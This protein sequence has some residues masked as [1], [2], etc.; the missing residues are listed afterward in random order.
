MAIRHLSELVRRQTEK[1]GDRKPA[2]RYRDDA[3][4]IWVPVS[5]KQFEQHVDEAANA[6]AV[7]GIEEEENVGI[8]SQNMVESFYVDFANF[9]NRAVTVP[10]YATSSAAQAQYI[11]NDTAMRLLFVG[12]QYQYDTIF[13][14]LAHCHTLQHIV[15][16]DP[17]VKRDPRDTISIYFDEFISKG[18]GL[19]KNDVVEARRA[20]GTPED[21]MNILY[22]SGT[23]GEPKGVMLTHANIIE[24]MR[25]HHMRLTNMNDSDVSLNFL[26]LTHVFERGWCYICMNEGVE[27]C[28]NKHPQDV[29]RAMKEV[30]P[31]LMCSVPRFWEKVYIGVKEKIEE[32]SPVMKKIMLDAIATGKKHNIDYLGKG[33]KPP[34]LLSMKYRLYDKTVFSLLKRTLGLENAKFFP[35]A[36]AAVATEV[37]EFTH[38]VGIYMMVGYGLTESTATVSN[39]PPD[40][41]VMGSVGELIDGLEVKIGEDD[42]VLLRGKT[43]MKGYYKKPEANAKAFDAEGYF[44]TGDTGRLEGRTLFLKERIKDLFK[45]SNGKYISPQ[46]IE[47]SLSIDKFIDQV[48]VIADGHKFVSALVV[49]NY[50]EVKDYARQNGI[51]CADMTSLLADSRIK[52][53]FQARIDTLQQ[54]YAHYEQI[55]RFTLLPQPFSMERGEITNTL[56]LRRSVVAEN[57]KVVIAKMYED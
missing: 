13:S 30:H 36:G 52:A 44:H 31:S 25:T 42:E 24:Q 8:F 16:Y 22:T 57:Y 48:A 14:S 40:R 38:S 17:T 26:P 28:V 46:A 53:L 43:I 11:I 21:L 2:L 51:E 32:Q 18:Q 35:T 56:K 37:C 47:A 49:P 12:E 34:M 39:F 45:T 55:K 1:Y 19:P 5:W 15:I 7:M 9:C 54:Q 4:G 41:F 23:T 29:Q 27:I 20:K 33:K 50:G 6:M 10:L 3:R